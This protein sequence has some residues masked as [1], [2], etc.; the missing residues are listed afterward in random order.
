MTAAAH[1]Q[2]SAHRRAFSVTVRT[3]DHR[4]TYPAIGATSA[5]VHAAA[6]DRFG[7]LCSV[8]VIPK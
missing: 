8:V 4:I 6:L 2:T 7:G 1:V 5:E 3:L